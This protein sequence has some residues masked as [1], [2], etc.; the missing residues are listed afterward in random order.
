MYVC[1]DGSYKFFTTCTS[2][3]V[4][5]TFNAF[6]QNSYM[7]TLNDFQYVSNLIQTAN[8]MIYVD[9]KPMLKRGSD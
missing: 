8:F 6:N 9:V 1:M 4:C 7:F 5:Y 2:T 3:E